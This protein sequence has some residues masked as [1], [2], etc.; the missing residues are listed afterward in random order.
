MVR[1]SQFL[2]RRLRIPLVLAPFLLVAFHISAQIPVITPKKNVT[3]VLDPVTGQKTVNLADVAT[4]SDTAGAKITISPAQFDCSTTGPQA[5]TVTLVTAPQVKFNDPKGI[6]ADKSGNFFI[7]DAGNHQIK[8]IAA[9]G[10]VTTIAGS[11]NDGNV[12]GVGAAA[13]FGN[14]GWLTIDSFGAVYVLDFEYNTIRKIAPNGTV[15]TFVSGLNA[16]SIVMDAN[17]NLF[18]AWDYE[19]LEFAPSGLSTVFAGS[20]VPG[21][22]DGPGA[23]ATFDFIN[24]LAFD[25]SGNLWV[26]D[27]GNALLR[28]ITPGGLVSTVPFEHQ[29]FPFGVSILDAKGDL[30]ISDIDVTIYELPAGSPAGI[31]FAGYYLNVGF[32]NGTGE[33]AAFNG[34]GQLAIDAAGN[35]YATDQ[36]NNAI[37]K[38]TQGAVV[39]TFAGGA[40]GNQDGNISDSSVTVTQTIPV[41]IKSSLTI[42]SSLPNVSLAVNSSCPTALPDYTQGITS[43]DNCS[44]NVHYTQS[45]AAGTPFSGSVPVTVTITATDDYGG[46]AT[47]AFTVTPDTTPVQPPELTITVPTSTVCAGTVVVFTA[48]GS[49]TGANP[50]Y[51]WMLN[52]N[53][54]GANSPVFQ[55]GNL[56][57][58][59]KILCVLTPASACLSPATSNAI[60]MTVNPLLQPAVK[61]SANANSFCAGFDEIVTATATGCGANPSYSWTLNGIPTGIIGPV[62]TNDHLAD[63]DQVNCLVTAAPSV[64]VVIDTASVGLNFSVSPL[65]TPTVQISGPGGSVCSGTDITFSAVVTGASSDALYQW[66]VNGAPAGTGGAAFTTGTLADGDIVACTLSTGGKCLVTTSAVSNQVPV[67]ITSLQPVIVQISPATVDVCAGTAVAFSAQATNTSS[68]MVYQWAVNQQPAGGDSPA[69]S[70]SALA[71]GDVVTCTVTD[72]GDCIAP[73]TSAAVSA[74]I[75]PLPSVSFNANPVISKGSSVQLAPV[76]SGDI[77]AW[78]WSPTTGLDN[79]SIADPAASPA[80]TTV[81]SL[82]VTTTEGCQAAGNVTVAVQSGVFP[83]NAFTPNG[84]GIND[85]WQVASLA[86]Y[87]GCKVDIFNRNGQLVFHSIGYA[88]PWDGTY[89][90]IRVASGTYYYVIDLNNG[91]SPIS[92]YVAVIR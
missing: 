58:G 50:S 26:C 49:N 19:I 36:T 68:N 32:R 60:T 17:N 77:V 2:L 33:A 69:F 55:S 54:V 16:T 7:S 88:R 64:C 83:P 42:T 15:T 9:N 80:V 72:A 85:T 37:R 91:H 65:V 51:Q 14:P 71:D 13:S 44:N 46:S 61:L 45:P 43:T 74:K 27:Y 3:L 56:Q 89:R 78:A 38:I 1:L 67:H 41:T 31:D 79:P 23:A 11:G 5:V 20:Q 25:H 22:A 84:D 62:Y 92:G 24:G 35:L 66:T 40:E 6:V 86:D 8:K 48:A 81:Y 76:L 28:E 18:V 34:L 47:A 82:T 30:F 87:P 90:S 57:N 75:E 53:A 12:D 63:G 39:T 21:S 4:V 59:D 29:F 73:S 52:G 10:I 70:T